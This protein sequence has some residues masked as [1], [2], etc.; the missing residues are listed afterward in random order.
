MFVIDF[1]TKKIKELDAFQICDFVNNLIDK[2]SKD[3]I[4]K[5]YL[6]LPDAAHALYI[7]EKA[8]Y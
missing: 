2:G 7:L 1:K 5:R 8:G 3:L 4:G 6:F